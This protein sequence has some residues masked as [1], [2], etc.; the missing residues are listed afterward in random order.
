[1][2][3]QRE[4][5]IYPFIVDDRA[6]FDSGQKILRELAERTGGVSSTTRAPPATSP[7]P[8]SQINRELRDRYTLV[9]RLARLKLDGSFHSVK[10]DCPYRA[11]QL[12]VRNGYFAAK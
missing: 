4:T 2:C 3:S 12:S 9:Y 1:M 7:I 10:L 8:S 6:H 11:T 5:P